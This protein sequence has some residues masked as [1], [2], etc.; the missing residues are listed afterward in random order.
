M[1]EDWFEFFYGTKEDWQIA[2]FSIMGI[3]ILYFIIK[4]VYSIFKK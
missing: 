4:L 2:F 3:L 1:F